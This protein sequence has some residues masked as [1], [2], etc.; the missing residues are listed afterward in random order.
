MVIGTTGFSDEQKSQITAAA[1]EIPVVFAPNMSVGVNLCLKLLDTA[2]RVLG[3]EV[4]IE[5]VEAHHRHKVLNILIA[6]Q[7]A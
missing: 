1:Q 5:V 7:A 3:D 2:A 4:D 6:L